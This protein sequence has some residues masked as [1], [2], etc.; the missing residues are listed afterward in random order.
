MI[1]ADLVL[2]FTASAPDKA[3]DIAVDY[4]IEKI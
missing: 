4:C 2:L 1:D 3:F